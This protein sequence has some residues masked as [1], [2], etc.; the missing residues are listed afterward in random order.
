[1]FGLANVR[2]PFQQLGGKTRGHFGRQKLLEQGRLARDGAGVVA[3]K[4][5]DL[6]FFDDNA[7]F[8][9]RLDQPEQLVHSARNLREQIGGVRLTCFGSGVNGFTRCRPELRE[10]A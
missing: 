10:R 7:A 9:I 8:E 1:L 4:D 3:K 6:I 2:P 5:A